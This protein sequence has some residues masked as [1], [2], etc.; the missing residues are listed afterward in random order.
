MPIIKF[1][2]MEKEIEVSGDTS[3]LQ[4]EQMLGIRQD[5][6]CG[7]HGKCGKCKVIMNGQE[8]LACKTMVSEDMTVTVEHELQEMQILEEGIS[9]G[10]MK[11]PENK[12]L[13]HPV[14]DG[15]CHIGVDIGTT[16]VAAYLL[17]GVSG[18]VLDTRSMLNPQFPYGSDVISR[19]QAA[20]DGKLTELTG[21]IRD[22]VWSL[23][24][25]LCEAN[26]LKTEEIGTMAVVANPAMQQIFF[27]VPVENLAKPPFSPVFTKAEVRRL[28]DYFPIHSECID[29]D[30]TDAKA[31]GEEKCH[32]TTASGTEGKLLVVPDIAGYVGSDTMGC[33]LSTGMYQDKQ[34]TLMIDIGTN[35]EMVLG[36][37]ERMAA[38]STA[39]GP[40]LEGGRISCGM[41][42]S[43]RAIDHVWI[44]DG[45]LYYSV[46]GDK[47]QKKVQ[48]HEATDAKV[49]CEREMP[50]RT[51]SKEACEKEMPDEADVKAVCEKGLCG[52]GI[53][54]VVAAMLDLGIVN[55]RGRIQK[56]YRGEG[57]ERIYDL[58]DHISLTQEDIREVQMAK[59]A[60][61]AGIHLLMKHLQVTMEDIDQVILCGAFGNYMKPE[62]ACRIGLLP[63]ELL[64]KIKAGGNAAGTGS[65]QMAVDCEKFYLTDE[66]QKKTEAIELASFPEFQR[67]YAENMMF[68]G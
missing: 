60:I 17:D 8:V 20:M 11:I 7:G 65:R 44:E 53:I 40:A 39:A 64:G 23:V 41:R 4:A 66:L 28:A 36:N 24:V 26:N 9:S 50:D 15:R 37:C 31:D 18:E 49:V 35:G 43:V 27:G 5:A 63:G 32:N 67:I 13:L 46:I 33:I 45:E 29:S 47:E 19:I 54:D 51:D 14:Q 48:K 59:G 10:K 61:A 3:I 6:P 58:T 52:S 42:G 16:T 57:K 68:P 38:C 25:G 21:L 22:G 55:K 12:I 34:M 1:L 62:S 2:P 30:R 56:D